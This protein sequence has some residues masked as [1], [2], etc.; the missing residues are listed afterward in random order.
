MAKRKQELTME[1]ETEEEFM[2]RITQLR[3]WTIFKS[4]FI[5]QVFSDERID[6]VLDMFKVIALI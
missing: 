1:E 5:V 2:I 6:E 4:D 3:I